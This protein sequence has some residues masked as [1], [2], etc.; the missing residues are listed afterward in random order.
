MLIFSKLPKIV[1]LQVPR[2]QKE[3]QNMGINFDKSVK[4][5]QLALRA[6]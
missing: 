1:A 5:G 2:S 3:P 6:V 4:R